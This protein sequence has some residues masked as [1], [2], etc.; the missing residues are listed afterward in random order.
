MRAFLFRHWFLVGLAVV[1]ALAASLPWIGAPGGPLKPALTVH[2][3]VA[4]AFLVSG[5]TLPLAHLHAA[6]GRWRLHLFIQGFSLLLV[7]A[8]VWTALPLLTLLGASQ[9]LSQGFL[10]LACLPTSIAS[11]VIFTRTARGN[12]AN[13]LCNSVLGTLLGLVMTPAMLVLL[14]G[15]HGEAP[16]TN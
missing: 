12:E 11:N 10:V 7:P 2:L 13:A 6:A 3:A 8:L 15:T 16:I 4:G 5:L 14:L 9:A 1:I